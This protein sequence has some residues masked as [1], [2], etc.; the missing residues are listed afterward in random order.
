MQVNRWLIIRTFLVVMAEWCGTPY[1]GLWRNAGR[2][3]YYP[4]LSTSYVNLCHKSGYL[5]F[6]TISLGKIL[7][8]GQAKSRYTHDFRSSEIKV[9]RPRPPPGMK[10]DCQEMKCFGRSLKHEALGRGSLVPIY[11]LLTNSVSHHLL[12]FNGISAKKGTVEDA[13]N[14]VLSTPADL[15]LPYYAL[16]L[17]ELLPAEGSVCWS[18]IGP[19]SAGHIGDVYV[20]SAI[21]YAG[22]DAEVAFRIYSLDNFRLH[23]SLKNSKW[24]S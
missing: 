21:R 23:A 4:E 1:T 24:F 20:E 8:I 11:S 10:E 14:I 9:R 12:T 5:M 22:R 15:V 18:L 19:I 3:W 6:H 2:L 16:S 17:E 7:L 13:V